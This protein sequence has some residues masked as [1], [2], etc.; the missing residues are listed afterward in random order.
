MANSFWLVS[1][2][3]FW[4]ELEEILHAHSK[5]LGKSARALEWDTEK[6]WKS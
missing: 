6:G 4:E 5:P 3:F 2:Y 1:T